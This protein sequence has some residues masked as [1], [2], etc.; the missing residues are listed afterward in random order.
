MSSQKKSVKK[1]LVLLAVSVGFMLLFSISFLLMS[2]GSDLALNTGKK[3]LQM[4]SGAMFWLSLIGAYSIYAVV[5]AMR[6]KQSGGKRVSDKYKLPGI[7]TFFSSKEAMVFDILT[8]VFLVALL[9]CW[10]G[11]KLNNMVVFVFVALFMLAFQLRAVLNGEN[12]RYIKSQMSG[13]K[14]DED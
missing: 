7:I 11:F 5:S 10:F 3:W 9:V 14:K 8:A 13:G 12:Y 2:P 4:L 1:I 6:K